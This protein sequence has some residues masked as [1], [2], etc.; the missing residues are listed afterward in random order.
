MTHDELIVKMQ[1]AGGTVIKYNYDKFAIYFA[2]ASLY[3]EYNPDTTTIV[4]YRVITRN[5][6]CKRFDNADDA[7]EHIVKWILP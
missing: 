7:Y 4:I 3:W 1:L 5:S 6:K 2:N